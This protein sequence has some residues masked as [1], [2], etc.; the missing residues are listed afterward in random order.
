MVLQ[1]EQ[2]GFWCHTLLMDVPEKIRFKLK[3]KKASFNK[4][5]KYLMLIYWRNPNLCKKRLV[6]TFLT[7]SS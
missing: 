5:L 4:H 3:G 2:T 1:D 6:K 7:L